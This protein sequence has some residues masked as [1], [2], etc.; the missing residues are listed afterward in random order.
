MI[1]A[2]AGEAAAEWP[3]PDEV[4][5]WEGRLPGLTL[6]EAP[7]ARVF[8]LAERSAAFAEAVVRFA[9]QVARGPVTNR[10]VDQLVGAASS[11]G[12]NYCE[13]DEAVSRRD[14]MHRVSVCAKEARET[15]SF[16]RLVAAAQPELKTAAR[17]PW[18][19]ARE[20]HLIFAAIFRQR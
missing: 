2:P 10:L 4:L 17:D 1:Q 14:F 5:W 15:A 7:P 3:A 20:L 11:I 6:E 19:E 9:R 16:L 18:R 8:D 12:A 13:A